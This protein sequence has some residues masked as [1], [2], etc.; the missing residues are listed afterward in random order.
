[1]MPVP[2]GFTY[3]PG[4]I[5][6]TGGDA[7]TSG[8]F[9]ATYCT[10][11]VADACTAQIAS[12]NYKT[13]YPYIETYLTVPISGGDNVTLPTVT[14]QFTASGTVGTV[15]PVLFT[16]F[17]TVTVGARSSARLT[18]DGYPSCSACALGRQPDL[19]GAVAQAT[20]HHHLHLGWPGHGD[21]RQPDQRTALRRDQRHHLGHRPEPGPPR[22]T[23]ARP[24]ATITADS[25][26]SITATAPGRAPEPST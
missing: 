17:V 13:V 3:V 8:N 1:M 25:A 20:H 24:P 5:S 6:V 15:V 11:A 14:A 9:K 21:G 19:L 7:T 22:W 10:A 16:E 26:T 4:S 18:F 2:K 23:S 12:G